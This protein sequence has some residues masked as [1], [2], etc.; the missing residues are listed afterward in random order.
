ML[1]R[2]MGH[3]RSRERMAAICQK[4]I[5]GMARNGIAEDVAPRIYN[6]INAFA[7]YGFPESRTR[8]ASRCSCTRRR[9]CKHYYAPEFTAAILNAQP[10]GFYAP[11]TLIED[12]RR[13]GVTV[14]P[15]DLTRSSWDH[16]LELAMGSCRAFGRNCEN[17]ARGHRAQAE[18]KTRPKPKEHTH[19]SRFHDPHLDS[20]SQARLATGP[21]PGRRPREK[22]ERRSLRPV[23]RHRRLRQAIGRGPGRV[24]ASLRSRGCSTAWWRTIRRTS[25]VASRCGRALDAMRG[26]AGPLAPRPEARAQNPEQTPTI[27]DHRD[28]T[29]RF[30]IPRRAPRSRATSPNFPLDVPPRANRRRLPRMTGLSLNGHPMRHL[31]KLLSPNA[32]RTA[33]DLMRNGRDGERAA[34]AGLVIV[35]QRPGTAK[36]FVFLSMEDE[37]G[38]LNVVV[39]PKRFER[40]ALLISNSP[41]AAGARRAAGGTRRR[42]PAWRNVPCTQG[43]RRRGR[44]KSHDFH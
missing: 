18:G 6:Q 2:A 44:A 41:P 39:T 1:R 5:D 25:A 16:T 3:K 14:R 28:V 12:A 15:I 37:T 7:D 21:R 4:L 23:R 9:T 10:M 29:K 42:E 34:H 17:E 32:I 33:D 24:R 20:C 36:G 38:I 30:T 31:R 35:R 22:L 26:E 8:R 27:H 13:H 43:R 40:Q 19:D 11:G